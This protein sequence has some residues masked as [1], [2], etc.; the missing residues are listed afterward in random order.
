MAAERVGRHARAL[1]AEEP[2]TR[3]GLAATQA[4]P[5]LL[6]PLAFVSPRII[7]AIIDGS[8]PAGILENY[9]SETAYRLATPRK[10]A[11]N[12]TT[13]DANSQM[14]RANRAFDVS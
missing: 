11:H 14:P 10:V 6:A 13:P 8:A 3:L 5:R 12:S 7:S 9:A 4:T 1:E 2:T